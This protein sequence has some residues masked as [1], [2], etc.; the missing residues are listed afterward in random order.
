MGLLVA[1]AWADG[2]L[3]EEERVGLHDAAQTLNLPKELRERME[4]FA[5]KKLS[6][7]DVKLDLLKGIERDFAYVASAW[8]ANVAHGLD[9]SEIAMLEEIGQRLGLDEAR[10]GEL[11]GMALDLAAPEAGE[12]WSQ[13]IRQLFS[14]IRTKVERTV[15]EVQVDFE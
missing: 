7:D 14:A 2:Q 13:G 15:E 9:D 8:M 11:A 3:D 5:E 12:S 10:Q 4:S 1:M 6:V